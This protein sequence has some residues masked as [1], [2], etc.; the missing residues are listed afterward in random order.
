MVLVDFKDYRAETELPGI[1]AATVAPNLFGSGT[2]A[3]AQFL[4]FESLNAYYA[5]A[6]EGKLN[7]QGNVLGWYH[8]SKARS[9]Y[10]PSSGSPADWNRAYFKMVKEAL[11]SYD[12]SHDFSQYDNDQDKDIDLVSIVYCGPDTGWGTFWW[13]YRSEFIVPE[14]KQQIFDDKRVKQFVFQFASQRGPG[15]SDFDPTTLIH[16]MGH[17]LGLADYYHYT[18]G[19]GPAGGLGGLDM[20]DKNWGNHNAFSRWLLDWISPEVIGSGPPSVRKLVASGSAMAG[21]KAVAIFPKASNTAAP[22]AEMFIIENRFRVG[23]DG[24]ISKTPGDGLLIWHIDARPNAINNDFLQNNSYTFNKLIRLVRADSPTDFADFDSASLSTYFNFPLE[25]TPTSTPNSS[26][27]FTGPTG[28]SVTAISRPGEVM[29]ALIGFGPLAPAAIRPG[30]LAVA[31]AEGERTG[32]P[33]AA[34]AIANQIAE[35]QLQLH[36]R[37]S[38]APR[39]ADDDVDIDQLERLADNLQ[40]ASPE[41]IKTVWNGVVANL[42]SVVNSRETAVTLR[43]ILTHWAAKDGPTAV[44]ALLGLPSALRR[45]IFQPVMEAWASNDPGAALEWYIDPHRAAKLKGMS[46]AAGPTFSQRVTRWTAL[47]G[48]DLGLATLRKLPHP[49]EV[50]AACHAFETVGKAVGLSQQAIS[51]RLKSVTEHAKTIR[52]YQEFQDVRESLYAVDPNIQ[53]KMY[54]MMGL[55]LH[56][57]S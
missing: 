41:T 4:P 14:A 26:S 35:V 10:E 46:L 15:L 42:P 29:T 20:M 53:R 18:G 52:V 13:A 19:N 21:N 51:E 38:P 56:D 34:N 16:E 25:F 36:K 33:D 9:E 45:S 54:E 32:R 3:A 55:S 43:L 1:T 47:N 57:S 24:G 23:N 5:R 6:S 50:L 31:Y 11:S 27:Y 37:L 39:P 40:N 22:E 28:V 2:A 30:E 8:F 12:A 48:L 7:V 44:T 17:S 49:E